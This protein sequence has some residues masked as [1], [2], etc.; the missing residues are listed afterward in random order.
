VND[1]PGF[2]RS[3]CGPEYPY[4]RWLRSG[5]AHC[6]E[7]PVQL[8]DE[9]RGPRSWGCAD[10]SDLL[11]AAAVFLED[12]DLTGPVTHVCTMALR[13]DENVVRIT[14]G[15]DIIDVGAVNSGQDQQPS[16][17]ARSCPRSEFASWASSRDSYCGLRTQTLGRVHATL[18]LF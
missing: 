8:G 4:S 16:R 9:Q 1:W 15:L 12:I 11:I 10:I 13:I 18:R 5:S 7:Q 6:Q 17:A 14:S 3:R 2:T